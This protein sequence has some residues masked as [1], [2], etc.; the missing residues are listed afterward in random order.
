MRDH[1]G[2]AFPAVTNLLHSRGECWRSARTTA[3]IARADE[4]KW[5]LMWHIQWEK[6]SISFASVFQKIEGSCGFGG[7]E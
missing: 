5:T 6:S 7:I 3:I 4:G 1:R 2:V